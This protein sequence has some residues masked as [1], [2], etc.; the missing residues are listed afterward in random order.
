M[1]RRFIKAQ[2]NNV[3]VNSTLYNNTESNILAEYS[4]TFDSA[5]LEDS[6]EFYLTIVRFQIPNILPIFTFKN[7]TYTVTLSYQGNDFPVNLVMKN[8]DINNPS[9]SIHTFQQFIDIINT[10]L[11]TSFTDL[12]TAFPAA[13]PTEAPF[14]V[15]NHTPDSFSLYTQQ[16]YDPVIA[17]GDTIEI[18]F[19]YDLYNFFYNSFKVENLGVNNPNNKD[20]RFIIED[21]RNNIPVSPV[22]Y[23]EF[24]QQIKTL[25]QWYDFE[26]ILFTSS[27]LP[28]SSEFIT[29]RTSDGRTINQ[30]I[31]TDF[32][33]S[34]GKD[35][36]AF[37]YNADP[38]R[39]IDM[40]GHNTIFK[41]DFRVLYLNKDGVIKPLV[42]PPKF[43]MS[44]KFGF[45]RKE[46]YQNN[47]V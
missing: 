43:N 27:S 36:S 28:I 21:E 30:P 26:S 2:D 42:I 7:N 22:N 15:Y 13:P 17:G 3:Y 5:L 40:N 10:G 34:L 46:S 23:Y 4:T 39:L 1:R 44:V 11:N 31:I 25:Y 18:Y 38:Y 29:S 8:V 14:M 24:K 35:R 6:G 41:F 47:Y 45:I 37:I 16:V 12:K 19:N 33:P 32:I 9:N 20:Y